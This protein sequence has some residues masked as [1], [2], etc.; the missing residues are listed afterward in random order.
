MGS[1]ATSVTPAPLGP[2]RF[3]LLVAAS[4]ALH[5]FVIST[6]VYRLDLNLA[7]TEPASRTIDATLIVEPPP[8]PPPPVRRV[9]PPKPRPAVPKPPPPP[10]APEPVAVVEPTPPPPDDDRDRPAPGEGDV[11]VM[12]DAILPPPTPVPDIALV[13]PAPEQPGVARGANLAAELSELGGAS[14]SLPAAGTYVYKLRDSRYS[15]LTGTTTI[16]WR[17]D[18]ATKRYETRLRSTVFGIQLADITSSGTIRRFGLAPERFV[19]KTGTKAPLAA[20]L[21]WDQHIVTFSSRSYQRPATEGMQDRVSFM[22]QLM[23]LGQNLPDAFREGTTVT[24]DVAGPGDIDAYHFTVVGTETVETAAGPIEAIKLDRPR[25]EPN[26]Q[27]VEVWLA[28][29]RRYLPV[30]VRFTDRRD[31]VTEMYFESANEGQGR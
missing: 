16:E 8:A 29:E 2:A 31:N 11:S 9:A 12:P 3:T 28:P 24:M 6:A 18:A 15:A 13:Q 19:Q 25:M 17:V 27:R 4:L 14:D 26:F 20:N 1:V 10:P 7:D 30:G 23:A 21:D 5:G 22:F